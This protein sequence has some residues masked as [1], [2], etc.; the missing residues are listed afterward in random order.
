MSEEPIRG[1]VLTNHE[2]QVR[3]IVRTITERGG[4]ELRTQES[5]QTIARW[6][7]DSG[8]IEE[9]HYNEATIFMDLRRA[10]E[11]S[12]G[13]KWRETSAAMENLGL[14][15]GEAAARYD[16][17][18]HTIGVRKAAEIAPAIQQAM[19]NKYENLPIYALAYYKNCFEIVS[20]AMRE[21]R[22]KRQQQNYLAV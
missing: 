4:M 8:F 20:K 1:D 5:L 6:L 15:A 10:Y 7:V 9:F 16:A 17:I 11:A 2:M 21:E 14:T 3:G 18:R 13:I 12:M 22:E 19:F